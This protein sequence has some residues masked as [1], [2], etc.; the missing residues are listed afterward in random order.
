MD[1]LGA[2]VLAASCKHS[3]ES[4]SSTYISGISLSIRVRESSSGNTRRRNRRSADFISGP[5]NKSRGREVERRRGI[6]GDALAKLSS[7]MA[8]EALVHEGSRTT[9]L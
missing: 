5:Y 7:P 4:R 6:L 8:H 3:N 2:V 9:V 1:Q